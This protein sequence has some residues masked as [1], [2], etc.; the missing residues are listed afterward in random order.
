MNKGVGMLGVEM[1][2]VRVLLPTDRDCKCHWERRKGQRPLYGHLSLVITRA[3]LPER[4]PRALSP[5]PPLPHFV[6]TQ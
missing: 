2:H 1:Q 6:R 5:A 4:G 3:N